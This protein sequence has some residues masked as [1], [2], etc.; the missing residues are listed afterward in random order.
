MSIIV[1][2]ISFWI[3]KND[4]V[5]PIPN[6]HYISG[7]FAISTV[8]LPM[9]RVDIFLLFICHDI[10]MLY[11]F[12]TWV[13]SIGSFSQ[14]QMHTLSGHLW[15]KQTPVYVLTISWDYGMALTATWTTLTHI[16][17]LYNNLL[18]SKMFWFCVFW[19]WKTF[20]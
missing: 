3:S 1:L 7:E 20:Q 5:I 12:K 2:T 14:K 8:D 9:F 16:C 18:H 13:Y 10:S 6:K 17:I 19:L 11:N 4:Y 15:K